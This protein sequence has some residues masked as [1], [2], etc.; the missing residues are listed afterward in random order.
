MSS[1]EGI[2]IVLIGESAVGKTSI[3]KRYTS[4]KFDLESISSLS[5][6]ISSKEIE[7]NSQIYNLDIWDT[8]GQE[9]YR[10]L[11]KIFYKNTKAIIFVY[12]I[13]NY[14]SFEELKKYWIPQTKEVSDENIVFALVGNKSDL[15]EKEEVNENE[16][17]EFAKQINA[18]FFLTSALDRSGIDDLF[19]NVAH[20]IIDPSFDY[21]KTRNLSGNNN[22]GVK[23]NAKNT[24]EKKRNCCRKNN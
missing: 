21:S 15:Y 3:I 24:D 6:Q 14:R 7:I 5:A 23:L 2:K 19:L 1:T 10:A 4:D 8:A 18:I 11:V 20:K 9:K 12:D 22:H 17:R 16:A 13:T